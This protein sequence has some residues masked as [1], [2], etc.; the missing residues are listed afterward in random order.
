MPR[1]TPRGQS[2]SD[3]P[4]ISVLT[5]TFDRPAYLRSAIASVVGQSFRD[6]ELIVCDDGDN[7]HVLAEFD[8]DRI[9]YLPGAGQSGVLRNSQRGWARARGRYIATL[10]DDDLW[11][12]DFL[13]ALVGDRKSVV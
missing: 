12:P 3:A 6:L 5:P 4:M 7:D 10:F 8:D 2:G 9:V 11:H 1:L 13:A